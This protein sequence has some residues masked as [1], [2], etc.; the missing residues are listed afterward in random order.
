MQEEREKERRK[1]EQGD[2]LT[3]EHSIAPKHGRPE[4]PYRPARQPAQEQPD[5]DAEEGKETGF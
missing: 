5:E 2:E 1:T 4:N 3:E